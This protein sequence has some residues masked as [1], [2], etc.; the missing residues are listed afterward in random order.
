KEGEDVAGHVPGL[1]GERHEG[2]GSPAPHELDAHQH[3]EGVPPDQHADETHGKDDGADQQVSRYRSG[4]ALPLLSGR[5][6][7]KTT[8]PI[9]ATSSI[10]A[11]TSNGKTWVVNSSRP[12]A[13]TVLKSAATSAWAS[14]A[15]RYAAATR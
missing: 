2:Q 14:S 8:T 13:R 7:T 6:S 4:H 1:P 12:R 3:D 15:V 5:R 11:A 9:T 10:S